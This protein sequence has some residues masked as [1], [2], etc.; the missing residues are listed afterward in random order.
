MAIIAVLGFL[1]TLSGYIVKITLRISAAESKAETAQTRADTASVN[2]AA[3]T[4]RV[5]TVA[6]LLSDHKE[7]VAMNYVSNKSLESLENRLVDAIGRLGDR[8]DRLFTAK[9]A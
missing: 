7:S 5:E 6:K 9:T 4:M 2:V 3:N 8:L 1:G